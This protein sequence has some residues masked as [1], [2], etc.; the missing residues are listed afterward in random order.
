MVRYKIYAEEKQAKH[1][2][3]GLLQHRAKTVTGI[4]ARPCACAHA[5]EHTLRKN[6]RGGI[7]VALPSV[8]GLL[9]RPTCSAGKVGSSSASSPAL[10]H[11][12]AL[13]ESAHHVCKALSA[14]L[15]Q[16]PEEQVNNLSKINRGYQL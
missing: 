5:V 11:L 8:H 12:L 2:S 1:R 9:A 15:L 3:N 10:A 7:Q 13:Q 6:P 16:L 4:N 14:L